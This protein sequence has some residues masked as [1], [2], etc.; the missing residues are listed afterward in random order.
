MSIAALFHS[1]KWKESQCLS[2]RKMDKQNV[3]YTYIRILL[4]HE[5]EEDFD[6]G[7]NVDESG[8]HYAQ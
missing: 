4:S 8:V 5:K 3:I 7:C 1:Q 6:T 2:T